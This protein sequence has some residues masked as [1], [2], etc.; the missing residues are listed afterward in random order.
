[1]LAFAVDHSAPATIILVT[2]DRDYAYAVSTLKLRKYRVIL[3]V[4]SSPHTSPSLESQASLV[5]DWSVAALRTRTAA[6]N[7]TQV[8]RQPYPELD[9]D[10]VA[11]LVRELHEPPPD[12]LD[13]ILHHDSSPSQNT[14][15]LRRISARDLLEPSI[16][17]KYT[18]SID[19]A[20]E[21]TPT[22]ESPKKSVSS[23]NDIAPGGQPI[24][25]T[26]SR[27]RGTSISIGSTRA[28]ST[29]IVAQSSPAATEQGFSAKSP[30]PPGT[31]RSS[32]SD[33]T[34]VVGP[35]KRSPSA[36]PSLDTLELPLQDGCPPSSII[37]RSPPESSQSGPVSGQMVA[38]SSHKLNS[39]ASPF[40]MAKAPAALEPTCPK[41]SYTTVAPTSPITTATKRLPE[42]ATSICETQRVKDFG[43][44]KETEWLTC[45]GIEDADTNP[46]RSIPHLVHS[47]EGTRDVPHTPKSNYQTCVAPHEMYSPLNG[48]VGSRLTNSPSPSPPAATP[49]RVGN[50][51]DSQ[52]AALSR[53]PNTLGH[54]AVS[55]GSFPSPDASPSTSFT[56]M[57]LHEHDE[58]RRRRTWTVFKPLIH[59]LLAAQGRGIIRPSRSTIAVDLVQSD[60]Q[61]YQRAGVSK[62][63]D[64]TAL[65][66]QAGIIELGGSA[67][68]AWIALH[69]NWFGMHGITTTHT[70]SS[71]SSSPTY[72]PPKTVQ[73][74]SLTGPKT[75][76]IERTAIFQST[77]VTS[78]KFNA[79]ESSDTLPTSP[80]NWQDSDPR[81][82]IPAQ[83]QPLIDVLT[84]MHAKGPHQ[85][86]RS[87]VGQLLG[88]NVYAQ[89][90]V[91]GFKEYV[92][93]ASEAQVVQCGGVGGYAWIR[94]HPEL[95]I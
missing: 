26:P 16:H 88:Q 90:G 42:I 1:M 57:G 7:S 35:A 11:K 46:E 72:D 70:L 91:S 49:P 17:H 87:A 51:V 80:A 55:R 86:L 20:Q 29:T 78:P 81:A 45:I 62:F 43:V 68:G 6:V 19:S 79:P 13:A 84:R 71:R 41:R 63:Q 33:L 5:I 60:K 94:L 36:L 9:A 95:R 18:G 82:A 21:F 54:S 14:S 73:N 3:V 75:P 92:H 2:G 93:Q 64:Y 58:I 4:P 8:V 69:P 39:L 44:P 76:L 74:P 66:E 67:G 31:R 59:L 56:T 65:A 32:P 38:P 23:G 83:F 50:D 40:V 89:A 15:R 27:S 85:I 47:K 12:D 24:P 10:L 52:F 77:T 22:P 28:R 37:V 61:V 30:T 25:K 34:D 48:N 53:V